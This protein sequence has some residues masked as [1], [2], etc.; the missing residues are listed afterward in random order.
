VIN[1]QPAKRHFPAW[2]TRCCLVHT[3]SLEIQRF[4]PPDGA[5][6]GILPAALLPK[7]KSPRCA[8]QRE[9]APSP[10]GLGSC[11]FSVERQ[12]PSGPFVIPEANSFHDSFISIASLAMRCWRP[13]R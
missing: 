5:D 2:C 13:D 12:R 10:Q 9:Q 4:V 8:A 1:I 7:L 11:T 3:P 6:V